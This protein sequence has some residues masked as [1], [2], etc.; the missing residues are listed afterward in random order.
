MLTMISLIL[1][2]AAWIIAILNLRKKRKHN[3]EKRRFILTI[4]SFSSCVCSL[5]IYIFDLTNLVKIED[6]TAL[7]D[8]S[9]TGAMAAFILSIMTIILNI[10]SLMLFT[11]G[12]ATD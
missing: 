2:F 7:M 11:G 10:L 3:N 12:T 1:G 5:C 6:W 9:P 8:I 4:I